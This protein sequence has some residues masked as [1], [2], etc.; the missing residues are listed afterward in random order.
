MKKHIKSSCF[1]LMATV[2]VTTTLFSLK[3]VSSSKDLRI[4]NIEALTDNELGGIM[5]RCRCHGDYC[6]GGNAISFRE[7]CYKETIHIDGVVDCTNYNS[8]CN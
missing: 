1:I 4:Q 8:D 2:V 5:F 7:L 6:Y 3:G